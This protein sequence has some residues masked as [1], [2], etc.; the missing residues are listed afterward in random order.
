MWGE[1]FS[2][3][4]NVDKIPREQARIKELSGSD[5][6]TESHRQINS[7]NVSNVFHKV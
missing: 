6:R 7:D 3:E 5:P 2:D 1:A 4:K